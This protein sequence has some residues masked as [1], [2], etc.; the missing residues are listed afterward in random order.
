MVGGGRVG[1]EVEVD[2]AGLESEV[3]VALVLVVLDVHRLAAGLLVLCRPLDQQ[4]L[5]VGAAAHGDGPARHVLRPG[6]LQAAALLRRERQ[7]VLA[8][9]GEVVLLLAFLGDGDVAEAGVVLGA[10]EADEDVLPGHGVDVGLEAEHVRHEVGEVG[11]DADDGLVVGGVEGQRC[12]GAG[13]GDEFQG[14]P[15]AD[16]LRDFLG[17]GGDL[18]GGDAVL[19]PADVDLRLA[20]GCGRDPGRAAVGGVGAAGEDEGGGESD[21]CRGGAAGGEGGHGGAPCVR[22]GWV[23][24]GPWR[25]RR[26]CARAAGRRGRPTAGPAPRRLRRP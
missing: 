1:A 21:R 17:Y 23:V 18:A 9:G 16:P 6:D 12:G 11:L 7:V 15:P 8:V 4:L 22:N 14:A 2:P 26:G 19:V 20:A 25:G 3:G 5:L 13:R 24:R 10:V